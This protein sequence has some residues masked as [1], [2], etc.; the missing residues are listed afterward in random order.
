[1]SLYLAV[2]PKS[3]VLTDDLHCVILSAV[4]SR[5]RLVFNVR[6]NSVE[7]VILGGDE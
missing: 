4:M 7:Q 6:N 1:M 3:G 2:P 5:G